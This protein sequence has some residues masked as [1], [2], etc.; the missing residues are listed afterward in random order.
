MLERYLRE[1]ASVHERLRNQNQQAQQHHHAELR[2]SLK[3]L[4]EKLKVFGPEEQIRDDLMLELELIE[5]DL[6]GREEVK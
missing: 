1:R 2:K 3:D 5:K 4:G 6:K